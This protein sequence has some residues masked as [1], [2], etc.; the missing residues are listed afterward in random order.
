M[1]TGQ[2][3]SFAV[4]AIIIPSD[5]Q[6]QDLSGIDDL[7]DS[8]SRL[9]LINP[10]VISRDGTLVAGERRLTACRQLGWTHIPIQ[11]TDEMDPAQL[12]LIEL[13]ENIKRKDLTWQEEAK[14]IEAYHTLSKSIHGKEWREKDT[15]RSIGLKQN[16]IS[17]YLSV[18]ENL[19]DEKVA[20]A[21]KLS[22]AAG[23]VTRKRERESASV[24]LDIKRSLGIEE[25][26]PS[27][28]PPLIN[29]SFS[30]WIEQQDGKSSFNFI[31]CDF[32]YGI[33]FDKQQGQNS[34]NRDRYE[35]SFET[36][37]AL[38]TDLDTAVKRGIVGES[39][40]LMFW[41][42]MSHFEYTKEKLEGQG[43]HVN[44]FP[45]IWGKSDNSGILPDP[46]RGPRRNYETAFLCSRGDRKICS[47]VSNVWWGARRAFPTH[48]S[49]KPL[50]ML[51]HFFRM[52]VDEHTIMLD[53]T[54]GG[55]SAVKAA[56]KAEAKFAMGLEVDK[57]T[58]AAALQGWEEM[59]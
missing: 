33:N 10:P 48:A 56:S 19:E 45:L 4:D 44:Q 49:E 27:E 15:G 34:A 40:H 59:G 22:V 23:Y 1:T 9:G 14:A 54:C 29:T 51:Q 30:E 39:A 6:R 53:P 20:T 37:E 3:H 18:A 32:P 28:T 47:A 7:A 2:F 55:G 25:D 41:F 12:H 57:E 26:E 42:S 17:Q 21:P 50:P 16:T 24:A 35:D 46:A 36:Y 38:I 13:E 43:W 8:I 31:H 11:Y 52:F 58:Y 5:R